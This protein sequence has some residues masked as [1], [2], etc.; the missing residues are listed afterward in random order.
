M[1]KTIDLTTLH[2]GAVVE[3]FNQAL[4]AVWDNIED[5]RTDPTAVR[6]INLK[7]KFKPSDERN[8]VDIKAQAIPKLVPPQGVETTAFIEKQDGKNVGRELSPSI[9]NPA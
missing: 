8:V 3:D 5:G 1:D 9:A 7:V 6:E 4:Q 2:D